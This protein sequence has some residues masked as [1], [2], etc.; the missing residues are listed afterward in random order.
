MNPVEILGIILIL[1]ALLFLFVLGIFAT[2]LSSRIS[3]DED[4]R[5]S[6]ERTKH[7]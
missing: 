1:A 3:N 5:N 6:N 2:M 7:E 4:F